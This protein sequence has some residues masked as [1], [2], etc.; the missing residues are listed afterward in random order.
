MAVSEKGRYTYMNRNQGSRKRVDTV[1]VACILILLCLLVV[2]AGVY[3]LR[4]NRKAR[5]TSFYGAMPPPPPE[6]NM[7]DTSGP[8]NKIMDGDRDDTGDNNDIGKNNDTENS[9]DISISTSNISDSAQKDEIE[10]IEVSRPVEKPVE[11]QTS[12]DEPGDTQSIIT[13]QPQARLAKEQAGTTQA[14]EPQPAPDPKVLKKEE[15]L[16]TAESIQ[17]YS[18]M[19]LD[20]ASN[21]NEINKQSGEVFRKWDVLL[22][23]IYQYLKTIMPED[24]FSV[25][26]KSELDWIVEKEQ[27]IDEAGAEWEGGS[28]E[29]MARNYT[30]IRY[31]KD[32]CFYLIDLIK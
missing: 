25:L 13:G 15:Y 29:P 32:R 23:D 8:E 30:G 14:S 21:Q 1:I 2:L 28:G 10:H 9:D 6:S 17:Q 16:K 26:Q 24:E 18:D 20:T 7:E 22:N 11:Q 4:S 19:Y 31:T 3:I 27:A 5:G 12:A